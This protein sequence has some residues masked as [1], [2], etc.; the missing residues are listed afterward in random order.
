MYIQFRSYVQ[1]IIKVTV[2]FSLALCFRKTILLSRKTF[3]SYSIAV[4][5]SYEVFEVAD[6]KLNFSKHTDYYDNLFRSIF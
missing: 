4:T 2:S 3:L 1:C 5:K 6:A